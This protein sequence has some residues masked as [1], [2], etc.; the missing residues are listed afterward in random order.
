M[1]K[2]ILLTGLLL[3]LGACQ[4]APKQQIQVQQAVASAHPMATAAGMEILNAGGN[5]FDA[6]VAVSATLAVV[7]PYSSGI[8]GGGFWLLHRASDRHSV[9]V[10]G[11]EVAP[12]NATRDM[13]LKKNGEVDPR[14]SI[15]GPRAAGIPGEPAALVYIAKHYGSLSLAQSLAP[16]IRAARQGFKVTPHYRRMAGFRLKVLRR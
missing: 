12:L 11:R 9:M 8:G 15:D 4:S 14:A 1:F 5:A 6:A 13:Y 3:L 16:A 7:E 2:K 10:D